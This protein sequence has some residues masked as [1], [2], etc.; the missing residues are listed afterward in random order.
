MKTRLLHPII[1]A[2]LFCVAQSLG[3]ALVGFVFTNVRRASD[4]NREGAV[5]FAV[6]KICL[7]LAP[8]VLVFLAINFISEKVKP[9]VV[10]FVLN[11]SVLIYFYASGMIQKDPASF[12]AG[13]LVTS[14][15]LLVIDKKVGIRNCL[16]NQ[17]SN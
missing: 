6:I 17:E 1:L 16:I 4:V 7:T 8:Y 2:L 14:I 10:S 3:E 9:A 12:I 11:L 15:V 13:S 5:F